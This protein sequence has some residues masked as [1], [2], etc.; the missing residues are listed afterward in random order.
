MEGEQPTTATSKDLPHPDSR[1]QLTL[2]DL[3][4]NVRV[5]TL[6]AMNIR[7][8]ESPSWKWCCIAC[9][10]LTNDGECQCTLINSADRQ[11]LI[12]NP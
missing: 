11:V 7:H 1:M 5:T 8:G 12:R 10:T 6:I 2:S 9:D 4:K 3:K